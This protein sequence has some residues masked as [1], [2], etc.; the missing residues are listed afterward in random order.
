[1]RYLQRATTQSQPGCGPAVNGIDHL[2][3]NAME[4]WLPVII[5]IVA[6]LIG[7]NLAGSANK[8]GGLGGLL[9][10]LVGAVG[11]LGGGQLLGALGVGGS[12]STDLMSIISDVVGGGAGGAILAGVVSML[13]GG[14]AKKA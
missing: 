9:G 11:G 1:R 10:S 6:G 7:G 13:K 3:V 14:S 4:T 12:S 5:Q 2:E 8:K